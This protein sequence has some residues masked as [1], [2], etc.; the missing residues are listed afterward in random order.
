MIDM[1]Y[2]VA[3]LIPVVPLLPTLSPR[4]P[5]VISCPAGSCVEQF[6][7]I[8]L[9]PE[10]V[11]STEVVPVDQQGE[12]AVPVPPPQDTDQQDCPQRVDYRSLHEERR[13]YLV[14]VQ[15]GER[16]EGGHRGGCR[17]GHRGRHPGGDGGHRGQGCARLIT[18]SHF[19]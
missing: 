9:S 2:E 6:I 11:S 19:R 15:T 12:E 8:N 4:R 18:S 17:G 1:S 7:A 16:Q 3:P 10:T 13:G 14:S 5:S